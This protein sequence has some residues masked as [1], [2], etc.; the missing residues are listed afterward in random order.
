MRNSTTKKVGF[1]LCG[2]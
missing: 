2:K 1:E